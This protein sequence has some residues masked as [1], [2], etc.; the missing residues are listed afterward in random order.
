M[1]IGQNA[2]K[3]TGLSCNHPSFLSR[4]QMTSVRGGVARNVAENMALLR[5]HPFLIS[6]VG[7]AIARMSLNLSELSR[8][9]MELIH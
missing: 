5:T 7:D 3:L 1:S 4:V 2:T 9:T 8:T 6:V